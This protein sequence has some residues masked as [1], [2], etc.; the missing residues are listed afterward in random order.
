MKKL[1]R[2]LAFTFLITTLFF[3]FSCESATSPDPEPI[4]WGNAPPEAAIGKWGLLYDTSV[5]PAEM[6]ITIEASGK[7]TLVSVTNNTASF[8]RLFGVIHAYDPTLTINGYWDEKKETYNKDT[9]RPVGFSN[10]VTTTYSSKSPWTRTLREERKYD[11][12]KTNTS[13]IFE[14]STDGTKLETSSRDKDPALLNK[15]IFTRRLI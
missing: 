1:A 7:V 8:E 14:V 12:V 13:T 9:L 4:D 10:S 11:D 5:G 3:L 15:K 2:L 6:T